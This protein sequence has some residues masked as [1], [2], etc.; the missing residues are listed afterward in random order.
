MLLSDL[1]KK[2]IVIWGLGR[3]ALAAAS[4]L[5]GRDIPF[6]FVDENPNASLPSPFAQCKLVCASEKEIGE[7]LSACEVVI[8]SPG[9]SL[10]HPLLEKEKS[11]SLVITSLLNIWL[12]ENP[13]LKTIAITGTKGKSTTSSLM[14]HVL[15]KLGRKVALVGNIGVPVTE[16][17]VAACDIAVIEVSSY[18]AA[19]LS[20]MCDVGVLVSFYPEHLNWHGSLARYMRDKYNLL[21]HSRKAFCE[22]K[23]S[24]I[25]VKDGLSVSSFALFDEASEAGLEN[26]YLSRAH[27]RGNVQ[28]VLAVCEALDFPREEALQ[29][30][31]DY[32]GLAHRQQEVGEVE[33]LL[34]VDDSISTTPQSTMAAM[35]VYEGRALTLIIGGQDRGLDYRILVRAIAAH[36]DIRVLC[37]GESGPRLH[38]ELADAG[39][40]RILICATMAE[41][42]KQAKAI[43]PKGGVVLLSP[44][45]PSYDMFKDFEDRAAAFIEMID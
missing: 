40:N 6:S 24:E 25:F 42:V 4:L 2:K 35:Q 23:A 44:A 13:S 27:N 11:R 10:Y 16:V 20:Q 37:L 5:A 9:V 12:A 33:G 30:M 38:K 32:K 15:T 29:A 3:E 17:D 28:A 21:V 22:R 39:V 7:A 45:A 36:P 8:K 1:A 18:Q 14:A 31:A 19:N 43:T 34:F 26:A 41:I